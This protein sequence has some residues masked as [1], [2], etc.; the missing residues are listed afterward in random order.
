LGVGWI[1]QGFVA[2]IPFPLTWP[3]QYPFAKSYKSKSLYE[4]VWICQIWCVYIYIYIHIYSTY[5]LVWNI[6]RICKVGW[7]N[8]FTAESLCQVEANIHLC[9]VSCR[10]QKSCSSIINYHNHRRSE[11]SQASS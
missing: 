3:L 8:R 6:Q 4:P 10:M 9:T 1:P 2:W 5:G 7:V 11:Q